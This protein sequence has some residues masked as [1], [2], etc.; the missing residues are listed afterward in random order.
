LIAM[1]TALVARPLRSLEYIAK[2][3]AG[4]AGTS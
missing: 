2:L 4:V 3:K 1:I